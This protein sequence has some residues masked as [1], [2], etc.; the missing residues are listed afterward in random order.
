VF[1]TPNGHINDEPDADGTGAGFQLQPSLAALEA[2][3]NDVAVIR[4]LTLKTPTEINS[5]EDI[6]RILTCADGPDKFMGYTPSIDHVV[7]N[8]IQQRPLVVAPEPNRDGNHWRNQ[9]SWREAEVAEPYLKDP[10]QVFSS[11]FGEGMGQEL[12]PAEVER[13]RAREQSLLDLVYD[14]IATFRTR[15][16]SDD[17]AHLDLYLDSLRAIESRVNGA[18]VAG[19]AGLCSPELLEA[20]IAGAPA[21]PVQNDDSSQNGLA[22][23]LQYNGELMVDLITSGFACGTRRVATLL[24]QGASEGLDPAKNEGSPNHHSISHS[25][26][27]DTWKAIDR[28]YTD[29]FLYTIESLKAVGM[30]DSTIVVWVTEIAQGHETGDFVNVV[31]G[32]SALG[33]KLGQHI[34]YEFSGNPGDRNVLREAQH[35]SLADLWVTVQQALGLSGDTFGDPE[36]STGPLVE[37]RG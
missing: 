9:L 7:G 10:A 28:W 31:A 36:W 35:R 5:H 29:R 24:W 33:M 27:F 4:G 34:H 18:G 21:T 2:H 15:V 20:R 1:F 6:C 23:D 17:R 8:A 12:D 26:D 25:T 22:E 19:P 14:D 13:A 16:N 32:G 3:N 37:L 11:L 30:L